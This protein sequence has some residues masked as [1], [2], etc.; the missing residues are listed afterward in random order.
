MGWKEL[1][2]GRIPN[3]RRNLEMIKSHG[4]LERIIV[5]VRIICTYTEEKQVRIPFRNI[6]KKT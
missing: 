3:R 2:P 1:Q 4:N 6:T 5:D